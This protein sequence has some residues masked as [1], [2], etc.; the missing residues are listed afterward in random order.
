MFIK[1]DPKGN[2]YKSLIDL[3]FD[4]C[5]EF[6]LVVRKDPG[7]YLNENGI[8][9]LERLKG[10]LKESKEQSEWVSN[11]L[12]G[13][14]ASV[15]YYSTNNQAREIVKEVSNSLHSWVQPNLPEDLCFLKNGSAWLINN[16]HEF[17]SYIETGNEEE[18]KKIKSIEGLDIRF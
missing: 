6:I 4:V 11:K 3:A 2:V 1:S 10:S 13:Q 16:A 8:S 17:E 12:Y 18:L 15:Y 7:L 9:V 14:N 5:D